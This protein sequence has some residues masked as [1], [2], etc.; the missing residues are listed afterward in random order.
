METSS[1]KSTSTLAIASL[2]LSCASVV[3]GP[4]GSIPGIILGH[5]ALKEIREN[6][7]LAGKGIAQAGRL[8]GII[9]TALYLIGFL[10]VLGI[11]AFGFVFTSPISFQ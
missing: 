2:V 8:I 11:L 10:V 6:D 7:S 3:L 9:F 5:M 1:Q 4:F